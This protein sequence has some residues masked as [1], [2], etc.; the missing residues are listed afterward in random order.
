MISCR[1]KAD[2]NMNKIA[3]YYRDTDT[4]QV[5]KAEAIKQGLVESLRM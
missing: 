1:N 4:L 5:S 3:V 2:G